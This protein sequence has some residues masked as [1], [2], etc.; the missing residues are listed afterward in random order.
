LAADWPALGLPVT[1]AVCGDETVEFLRQDKSYTAYYQ[2]AGWAADLI[3]LNGF[4]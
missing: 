3:Y 4:K 2:T 1:A